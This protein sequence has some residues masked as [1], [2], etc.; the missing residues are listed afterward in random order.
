VRRF[1]VSGL[2]GAPSRTEATPGPGAARRPASPTAAT[3][4][5]TLPG[6]LPA[7]RPPAIESATTPPR[8]VPLAEHRGQAASPPPQASSFWSRIGQRASQMIDTKKVLFEPAE[9]FEGDWQAQASRDV[10]RRWVETQI[11]H[12][13]SQVSVTALSRM[14]ALEFERKHP[15]LP[16]DR[17]LLPAGAGKQAYHE[18]QIRAFLEAVGEKDPEAVLRSFKN[19]GTGAL[20][21]QH[22]TVAASAGGVIGAAQL[23]VPDPTAKAVLASVRMALQMVTNKLVV[24]AGLRRDR[25]AN[26][27]EVMPLGKADAAPSAKAAPDI[28][29]ASGRVLTQLQGVT[30]NLR[31]ME[32]ALAGLA[33]CHDHHAATG[34]LQSLR[35]VE[36]AKDR[37]DIAFAK[38]CHQAEVKSQYKA[39]SESTKVEFRGNERNLYASYIGGTLGYVASLMT[40]LTPVVISA[41][42]TG[43]FSA[44]AVGVAAALYIGYQLSN[45]PQKDGEAKARRAIVAL[46]KS[47]DLLAGGKLPSQ[48]QRAEAYAGYRRHGDQGRLLARLREIAQQERGVP[49]PMGPRENWEAFTAYEAARRAAATPEAGAALKADFEAAHAADFDTA[50]AADAWKLPLRM[51]FDNARRL[52]AGGVAQAHRAMLK[53]DDE[54]AKGK[55]RRPGW[56][57]AHAQA[58]QRLDDR[59]KARLLDLFNLELALSRMKPMI[60]SGQPGDDA[61]MDLAAQALGAVQNPDVRNLFCGDGREQ[62]EAMK[63]AKRLAAGESE[64][65]TYTN[66]GGSMMVM[67]SNQAVLAA[68]AGLTIERAEAA[69]HGI[70]L[71]DRFSDERNAVLV[72]QT[73][74]TMTAH[75]TAGE[76]TG[77]QQRKMKPLL[78]TIARRGERIESRATL[79]TAPMAQLSADHPQVAAALD[80]LVGQMR[81]APGVPDEVALAGPASGQAALAVNLQP[82]THYQKRQYETASA[83]SKARFHLRQAGMMAGHAMV[84]LAGVPAQLAAQIPLKATRQPLAEAAA[85]APRVRAMLAHGAPPL[86]QPEAVPRDDWAGTLQQALDEAAEHARR[87]DPPSST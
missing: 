23:L 20:H 12:E 76:R 64:R 62:V 43:G 35:A 48:Q 47:V 8:R 29:H 28:L 37:L 5:P 39:S 22:A 36:Q 40:I 6:G 19:T 1:N 9:R 3:A 44:A 69:A 16:A 68:S 4:L 58:R 74:A 52:V 87:G 49:E 13:A 25:N 11:G 32:A 54:A 83:G 31:E 26:T 21:R 17:R 2:L 67:L 14:Q 41:P 71:Q 33:Q 7:G 60:E 61:A 84:S 42:A 57:Q 18:A 10:C 45:G 85:L 86:P 46:G 73:G 50:L 80:E 81:R 75:H 53:F 15:D 27:E 78:A 30:K 55:L 65:Y 82:T 66:F 24:D 77:F 56:E 59:L 70:K 79:A 72:S 63:R 51:R 34:T 38:F